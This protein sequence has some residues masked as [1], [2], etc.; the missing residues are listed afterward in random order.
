MNII[1][2]IYLILSPLT[3]TFF[4]S[5]GYVFQNAASTLSLTVWAT[6]M[7]S[8]ICSRTKE[9]SMRCATS[10]SIVSAS[11]F[12]VMTVFIISVSLVIQEAPPIL[13]LIQALT[14]GILTFIPIGIVIYSIVILNQV[15][16]LI[17][18]EQRQKLKRVCL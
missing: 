4:E 7:T 18:D 15:I 3:Y 16:S 11:I 6:L 14:L 12:F 17:S 1:I 2:K 8:T 10:L 9:K 5:L 13:E